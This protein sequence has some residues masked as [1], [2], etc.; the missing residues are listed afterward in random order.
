MN[1]AYK[2]K[3]KLDMEAGQF[4]RSDIDEH[5]GATDALIVISC[6]YPEDGTYSQNFY[7]FDGR[8][9]QND[10]SAN[11]LFKAWMM[12]GEALVRRGDVPGANATALNAAMDAA[13]H[14]VFRR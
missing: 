10:L 7:S 8:N 9:E 5:H 4:A 12:M 1:H 6:I 11:D 13:R 14:I 2:L 3:Y